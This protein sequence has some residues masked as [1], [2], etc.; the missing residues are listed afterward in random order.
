MIILFNEQKIASLQKIPKMVVTAKHLN[1]LSPLAKQK[2]RDFQ[3]LQK[4]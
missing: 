4:H 2:Q 1:S 3:S